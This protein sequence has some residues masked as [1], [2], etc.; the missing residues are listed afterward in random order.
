MPRRFSREQAMPT[1]SME[2]NPCRALKSMDFSILW[3]GNQPVRHTLLMAVLHRNF[4]NG[5]QKNMATNWLLIMIS[6]SPPLSRID[7]QKANYFPKT[8]WMLLW[9]ITMTPLS[10]IM[11]SKPSEMLISIRWELSS[12]IMS[13]FQT[14]TGPTISQLGKRRPLIR[15]YFLTCYSDF[16]FIQRVLDHDMTVWLDLIATPNNHLGKLEVYGNEIT[17]EIAQKVIKTISKRYDPR[18]ALP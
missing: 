4:L 16:R 7:W 6:V 9:L 5:H 10:R 13:F 17:P 1:Y 3:R 14:Q 2:I 12:R 11:T 18:V 15:I 8:N